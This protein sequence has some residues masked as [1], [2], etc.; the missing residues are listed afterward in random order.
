MRRIEETLTEVHTWV[1]DMRETVKEHNYFING[2]G[3]PGA[4]VRVDRLEQADQRRKWLI[5]AMSLPVIGVLLDWIIRHWS[6]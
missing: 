4:K 3:T 6:S 5:R 1:K 2:N